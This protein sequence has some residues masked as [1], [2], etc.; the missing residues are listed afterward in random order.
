MAFPARKVFG[1]LEKQAPARFSGT[2]PPLYDSV[3][4]E[5]LK[6]VPVSRVAQSLVTRVQSRFS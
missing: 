1:T 3:V 6:P 5:Q 2:Q 4:Y